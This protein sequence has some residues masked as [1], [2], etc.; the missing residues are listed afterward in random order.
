MDTR[1]GAALAAAG[2]TSMPTVRWVP[3]VAY[4]TPGA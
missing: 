3:L 2:V 1:L 4:H